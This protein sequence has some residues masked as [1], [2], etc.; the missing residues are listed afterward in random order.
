MVSYGDERS[1]SWDDAL[2]SLCSKPFEQSVFV[3]DGLDPSQQE[4]QELF[5]GIRVATPDALELLG[6]EARG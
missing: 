3:T 4:I 5:P 2:R 6:S 1:G